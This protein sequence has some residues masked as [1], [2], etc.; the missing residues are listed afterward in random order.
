MDWLLAGHG[1]IYIHPG[2]LHSTSFK[3]P[4]EFAAD[5]LRGRRTRHLDTA[6]G[7]LEDSSSQS[8]RESLP[9]QMSDSWLVSDISL[10]LEI[11]RSTNSLFFV[12]HVYLYILFRLTYVIYFFFNVKSVFLLLNYSQYI[13]KKQQLKLDYNDEILLLILYYHRCQKQIFSTFKFTNLKGLWVRWTFV[14]VKWA[15]LPRKRSTELS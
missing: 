12:R 6:V 8:K 1:C 4:T 11:P 2:H 15:R 3:L 13:F 10:T 9:I 5:T 7:D 14:F